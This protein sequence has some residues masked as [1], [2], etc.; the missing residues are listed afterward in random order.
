M[1]LATIPAFY[2]IDGIDSNNRNGNFIEPNVGPTELTAVVADGD[3]SITD[4]MNAVQIAFNNAANADITVTFDRVTRLVTIASTDD[5]DLLVTTGSNA[6]NSFWS[7]IGFTTD[8]TG[9]TTYV[10]D[11][12]IATVYSP[13]FL[14][15]NYVSFD[16]YE[17][18]IEES[19]N[20]SAG[21]VVEAVT[22]TRIAKME[23]N[24][25][26]I[27]DRPRSKNS[28]IRNNPNARAEA[29]AL[30]RFLAN[31]TELEFME[32]RDNPAVFSKVLLESIRGNSAG[33]GFKLRELL[34]QVDVFETGLMTFRK[35]L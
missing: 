1:A 19:I 20:E 4:L 5:I 12:P 16:D 13:Q 15:Q 24:F 22:F 28:A 11:Q 2:Y 35:I 10:G 23:I 31:K 30:L 27:Q 8:R 25:T 33:T 17:D 9:G 6:A 26:Q 3:R 14:A 32:D 18:N 7:L 34:P 21:G 29:R